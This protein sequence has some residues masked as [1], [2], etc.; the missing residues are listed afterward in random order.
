[1]A[2]TVRIEN[3]VA[4]FNKGDRRSFGEV[5]D[6]LSG[7]V[8]RYVSYRV[9]DPF[10]REEIVSDVFFKMLRSEKLPQDFPALRRFSYAVARNAVIDRYRSRKH[11]DDLDDADASGK[12]AH[13]VDHA[14]K[15]DDSSTIGRILG[16]LETV[17]PEYKEILILRIWDDL[18]YEDISGITG[19]S[20]DN[21]KKIVSR[22]L[23]NIR[24]NVA[25]AFFFAFFIR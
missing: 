17:S 3:A 20:V 1:M 12:T 2:D 24:S 8:F 22:V 14:S 4:D 5:F 16:Y 23:E 10:E 25:Y 11:T 15:I 6:A 21:C 9:E 7:D 19:K 13:S 18:P